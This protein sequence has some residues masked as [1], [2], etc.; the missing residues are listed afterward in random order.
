MSFESVKLLE[1]DEYIFEHMV[2]WV[3]EIWKH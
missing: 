2:I 3:L 1:E